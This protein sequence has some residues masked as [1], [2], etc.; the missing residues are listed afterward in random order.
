MTDSYKLPNRRTNRSGISLMEVLISI[1]IIAIGIFGVASLIPVAQFKVAEGTS[2]DR[3]ASLGPSAAAQFRI[4]GMG[5]PNN[6]VVSSNWLYEYPGG[7]ERELSKATGSYLKPQPYCIDPLGLAENPATP[8]I[9]FPST[10]VEGSPYLAMPRIGLEGIN[11]T[12]PAVGLA[13]AR[14]HF[15]LKDELIFDQPDDQAQAPRRQFFVDQ[16]GN[17][18]NSVA[19]A[20]LSW[21]ATLS[22]TG[23][24]VQPNKEEYILSIVVVKNR[25]PALVLTEENFAA[26][27]SR[28]AG[29]VVLQGAPGSDDQMKV[30]DLEVG[31]WLL[32][33][34]PV[35]PPEFGDFVCRWTQ[36]IGSS[37]EESAEQKSFTVGNDDFF[38]PVAPGQSPFEAGGSAIFARGVKAVYER[39]IRLEKL[40]S[41]RLR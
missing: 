38:R 13:L 1:G 40:R 39:T 35:G 27:G 37:S 32:L 8:P 16:S 26:A 12:A 3:V 28:F 10:S 7:P 24:A 15:Y 4:Q 17:P 31:D 36:I 30:S 22:P 20:S 33:S 19:T 11:D 9:F 21:F 29:E 2:N 5:D 23:V 18:I 34:K 25:I 6:W 41:A 14:S